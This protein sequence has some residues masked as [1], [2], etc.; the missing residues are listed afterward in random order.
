[1]DNFPDAHLPKGNLVPE[2]V[3]RLF[4]LIIATLVLGIAACSGNKGVS[5][6]DVHTQVFSELRIAVRDVVIDQERQDAAIEIVDQIESDIQNLHDSLI[7]KRA[8]LRRLNANYDTTKEELIDFSH[9]IEREIQENQQ[10]ASETHQELIEVT[11][12]DE[13]SALA[14]FDEKSVKTITRS[15]KGI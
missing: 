14:K 3:N 1:L 8:E 12:P 15:L 4:K 6:A 9:A 13:W 11:T 2:N 5:P 7:R 10:R